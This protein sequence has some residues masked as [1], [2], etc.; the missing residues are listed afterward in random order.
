MAHDAGALIVISSDAHARAAFDSLTWGVVM[1]RR[2]WLQAG[3][4]LN[5]RSF[6]D[7]RSALRRHRSASR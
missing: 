6:E 4:V 2:A 1:A 7:F 3:D 5:T